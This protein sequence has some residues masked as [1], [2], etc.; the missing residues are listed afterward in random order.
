VKS[1][2]I[3]FACIVAFCWIIIRIEYGPLG[4]YGWVVLVL[5]ALLLAGIISSFMN[6]WSRVAKLEVKVSELKKKTDPLPEEEP[7]E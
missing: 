5:V 3:S 1:F 6:L 7:G 4:H 2:I